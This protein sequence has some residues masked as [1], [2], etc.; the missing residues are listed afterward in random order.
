[1]AT[2]VEAIEAKGHHGEDHHHVPGLQHQFDDIEQQKEATTIGMWFFL[3]QEVMFFGGLF[4]AYLLFRYQY[5]IA[6]AAASNH[7]DLWLGFAN[8]L[9]LIA[10][11]L[12]MALAV[13]SAQTSKRPK[14]IAG[15]IVLTMIFG[16][17]FLGV[18]AVEYYDKYEHH[19]IPFS[20]SFKWAPEGEELAA[21]QQLIDRHATELEKTYYGG[22]EQGFGDKVRIFFWIYFAMTGLHAL[23]MVIGIGIMLW[24]L[25]TT[26]KGR[27][28]AA[29]YAPVEIAGLYW[30]FVDIVWIF[31]FPLL[32]LLGRHFGAGH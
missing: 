3:V 8:T 16:L 14:V 29:F 32:Y 22:R 25:W 9:V 15:W 27:Y 12:T 7:L 10:S 5:P 13:W 6:F 2:R 31:L 17:V 26:L 18:K 23:H 4:M 24:L 30:H 19:L 11:S 1:M 28:S 20:A 21:Q